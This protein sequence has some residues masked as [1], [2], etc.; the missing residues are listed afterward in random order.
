MSSRMLEESH[1]RLRITEIYDDQPGMC[2]PSCAFEVIQLGCQHLV[3]GSIRLA[4]DV[5]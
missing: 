3:N 2:W 5:A 1:R 4:A